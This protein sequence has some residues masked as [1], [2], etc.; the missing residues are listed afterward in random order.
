MNRNDATTQRE[1]HE[2]RMRW[3]KLTQIVGI[4][5]AT[6]LRRCVVAVNFQDGYFRTA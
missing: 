5:V 4:G 3:I 6:S 1:R 2:M